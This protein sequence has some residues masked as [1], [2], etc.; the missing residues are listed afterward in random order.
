[1]I[2]CINQAHAERVKRLL[3]A[4]FTEQHED[5]Y[6]QAA[7]SIITGKSDQVDK[8]IRLYKNE[9]FPNIAIT[10]DLLTTGIDVPRIC[11]LVF[12]RRVRSRILYEQMKGRATRRCDD[13]GKT[14]FRIYD[15]VDLYAALQAVDTM[16]PLVK[17]PDIPLAQL[18]AELGISTSFD[19]PGNREGTSHANDVLDEL[20]QRVMRILRKA[21]HKAETKPTL[22]ARLDELHTVWGVAPAELHKHLH[23]IGPQ[24]AAQFVATH[25]RLL[26]QLEGVRALLASENYPVISTHTDELMVREQSY[27]ANQKP[28]DYLES[29]NDFVRNQLNQ[30][31]ALGVVVNR[32]KDLTREHLR[33]V[34]LLLDNAGYSEANLVSAWRNATN[35]EIAAS[36]IGYIRQ[37]ALGEA[38]LPF[39]QR[40]AQAMQQIYAQRAWTQSQ[41]R[42]LERLAKQLVH[43][44]VL[45]SSQLN[46]AFR[47]TGGLK[48][49]DKNLDGNLN[50]VIQ[51]LNDNLWPQVV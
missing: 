44:V 24:Q 15:P 5:A 25:S 13:I 48:L 18:V 7:V 9:R 39:D 34:R 12:M 28:Q 10:V 6:N 32:P 20:S 23:E 42:L 16:K 50:S 49:L 45:D 26:E 36:I 11:N 17:N 38:L 41:R 43:E 3:D 22:K 8:L 29:F 30:S 2:F 31:V 19:A 40:V 35:Q 47:E 46:A 33:E 51:A 37:A 21:Q 27:G 4:A 1:M 14:V